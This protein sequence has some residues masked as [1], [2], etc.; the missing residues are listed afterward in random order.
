MKRGRLTSGRLSSR[1]SIHSSL[2][3]RTVMAMIRQQVQKGLEDVSTMYTRAAAMLQ[4]YDAG[5]GKACAV[6]AV[7]ETLCVSSDFC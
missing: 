6:A 4:T 2:T 5:L 7:A 1:H 3:A